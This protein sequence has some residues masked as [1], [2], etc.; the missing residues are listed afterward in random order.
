MDTL[1]SDPETAIPLPDPRTTGPESLE[2]TIADRRS[3]RR[4]GG[5]P[6]AL[7]T[8][9]QLLW[10]AQGVTDQ[11]DDFRAVPSAGATYPLKVLLAV[12]EDGVETTEAGVYHYR[13]GPHNLEVQQRGSVH[14]A[15]REASLDQAW[16]EDA[17]V[18]IL[19][20]GRDA[21]TEAEYGDRGSSRYVPMEVG[22]AGQNIYLQAEALDLGT[23]SVGAFEDEAVSGVMG[24]P[25]GL[26]PLYL[27]PV[28]QVADS[29]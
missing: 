9:G 19:L 16:I 8:V 23:V 20:A 29:G 2:A 4:L 25:S 5:G 1:K 12:A 18:D 6:L 10:A 14:E 13:P 21:R 22:H 26:R 7:A 3:R 28:G 17:P 11:A 27:F 15:L 24:L